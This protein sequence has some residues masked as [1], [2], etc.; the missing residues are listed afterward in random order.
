MHRTAPPSSP[1]RLAAGTRAPSKL[2]AA[3][4]LARMPHL[5]SIFWPSENPS[6]PFGTRNSEMALLSGT[7][8]PPVRAYT[9]NTSPSSPS[10]I[11]P[12]VIHIFW[13]LSSQSPE[14]S[15]A[16]VARVAR[17]STSVPYP[18]SLMHMPPTSSPELVRGSHSS[19]SLDIK[20]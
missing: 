12:L 8:L 18:G 5:S 4:V 9:R 3:V 6:V 20:K 14:P 17:P 15:S 7:S 2:S 13:P 16:R 10:A 11:E 1:T 19:C